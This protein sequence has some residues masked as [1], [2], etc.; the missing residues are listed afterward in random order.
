MLITCCYV[1]EQEV[2]TSECVIFG[3]RGGG[4]GV[5]GKIVGYRSV[6]GE[7]EVYDAVM[8]GGRI[9]IHD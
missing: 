1:H 4:S 9:G 8:K 6:G 7:H 3:K 5:W 2:S